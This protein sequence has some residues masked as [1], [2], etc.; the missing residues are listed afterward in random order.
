[1][2]GRGRRNDIQDGEGR[3]ET[4]GGCG[5]GVLEDTKD[6]R[7]SHVAEHLDLVAPVSGLLYLCGLPGVPELGRTGAAPVGHG[8]AMDSG[9]FSGRADCASLSK[10]RQDVLLLGGK[11]WFGHKLTRALITRFQFIGGCGG[12]GLDLRRDVA[13]KGEYISE[14]V[15]IAF[16]APAGSRAGVDKDSTWQICVSKDVS[17]RRTW[18]AR[19]T[20][21]HGSQAL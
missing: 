20:A 11:N 9:G 6:G 19:G 17:N 3:F 2:R 4:H 13:N 5:P 21:I 16:R 12:W 8:V 10:E 15:V 14:I 18:V 1:M 7:D